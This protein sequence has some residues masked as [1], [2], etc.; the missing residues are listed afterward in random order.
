[1]SFLSLLV[2]PVVLITV[3]EPRSPAA[4]C[5]GTNDG[6][7]GLLPPLHCCHFLCSFPWLPLFCHQPLKL[8][9]N[10]YSFELFHFPEHALA[11]RQ[12]LS[13]ET[14]LLWHELGLPGCHHSACLQKMERCPFG[15]DGSLK[16]PVLINNFSWLGMTFSPFCCVHNTLM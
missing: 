3:P 8:K 12:P 6:L 13:E 15:E 7:P 1:M 5:M 14:L 16:M 2:R 11:H 9:E 10:L 4:L